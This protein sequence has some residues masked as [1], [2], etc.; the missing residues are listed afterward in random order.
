MTQRRRKNVARATCGRWMCVLVASALGVGGG[1]LQAQEISKVPRM[2]PTAH[3]S[4]EVATVKRSDPDDQ[5]RRFNVDGRRVLVENQTVSA[6]MEVAFGVH[7]KQIQNLPAWAVTERFDVQGV[8]DEDGEPSLTQFRE[9]LRK[10]LEDRFGLRLHTERRDMDRYA[11]AIAKGGPKLEP[12]KSPPEALQTSN[13]SGTKTSMSL[14]ITN[15]SMENLILELQSARDRPV[16]DETGLKGRFDFSLTWARDDAP[17]V[18]A[19][20]PLPGFFTAIQEQM[21]L[22]LE[23]SKGP[24]NVLVV[25]KVELPSTN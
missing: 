1:C 13:G 5:R 9:M 6:M 19:D 22:K 4:F 21:G 3:P 2:S 23:P 11:L 24:V 12:S 7:P 14:K 10:L 15:V 20:N 16:V 18:D 25:D 8:P 17:T